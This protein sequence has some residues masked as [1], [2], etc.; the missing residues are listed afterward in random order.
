MDNTILYI[1]IA[2]LAV[3]MFVNARNTRKRARETAERL[4]AIGVGT[5][6]MTNSGMYGTILTIDED[7]N[8]VTIESTPGTVIMIHRQTIL[9]VADYAT[10]VDS[11]EA[12]ADSTDDAPQ[13]E[14][15]V[16]HAISSEEPAFGE[17][18]DPQAAKPV[19]KT[20]K[21]PTE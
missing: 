2:L 7:T 20:A 8:V 18:V 19:R 16:D 6:I 9:K 3:F 13:A 12:A 15:N 1:G 17:R 5:E 14:L 11:D 10:V 21:K 4:A